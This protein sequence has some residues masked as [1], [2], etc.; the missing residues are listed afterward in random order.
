MHPLFRWIGLFVIIVGTFFLISNDTH[1][2]E[3]IQSISDSVLLGIEKTTNSIKD[4]Y[5]NHSCDEPLVYTLGQVDEGFGLS[6]EEIVDLLK[7]SEDVWENISERELFV[8]EEGAEGA[9]VVNFIFDNRQQEI[10]DSRSSE[11]FLDQ[12]WSSY[13]KLVDQYDVLSL[14]H[15]R[16]VNEY[17]SNVKEYE[18][19]LEKYNARVEIWNKNGGSQRELKD[20]RQDEFFI[21]TVYKGLNEEQERLNRTTD[22]INNLADEINILQKDLNY[23]TDLHNQQFVKED[24]I[25]SGDYGQYEIN[26]YQYY[27]I[28]DLKLT[29]AHELGHAL[30]MDHVEDPKSI[31]YYLLDEQDVLH[32]RPSVEDI[33][34]LTLLCN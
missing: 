30:G 15:D 32:L 25:Q 8:F 14:Q 18:S 24:V 9:V 26:I 17:E 31:M 21:Q 7:E 22:Q 4:L 29:L 13:E 6:R 12:K 3:R 16:L 2:K 33:A 27:S 5:P 20:L 34:E 19:L 1:V 10:I 11:E 23:Q 28:P